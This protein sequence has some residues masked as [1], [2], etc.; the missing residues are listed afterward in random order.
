[1]ISCNMNVLVLFPIFKDSFVSNI[2]KLWAV[3]NILLSYD[4]KKVISINFIQVQIKWA[5]KQKVD[6][7]F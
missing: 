4:F 5:V 6:E 7:H 1:M 2:C 3:V